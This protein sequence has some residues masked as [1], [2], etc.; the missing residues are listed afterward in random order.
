LLDDALPRD[1]QAALT[2]H[3]EACAAC[4]DLFAALA[5]GEP[6]W[7]AARELA[8]ASETQT[9]PGEGRFRAPSGLPFLEPSDEEGRIGR[10][11]PYEVMA[12]V[13]R[14]GMGV[15]LKA[16]D[17]SLH[18]VVAVKVLA[19]QLSAGVA[20]RKRFV[21]EARAAASVAHEHVVTIHA[22]DEWKGWPFLVMQYVGGKSLQERIDRSGPLEVKEILRIGMQAA[23][24]L[25]AAHAQGLVHRDIKP[26]NILLENGVERVKLTDFG[27]ARAVDDPSLTQAGVVAGTPQYMSPEQ[28]KGEAVD[29]RSDLFSL[30]S[31][32][33]A[34]ATGRPP[35]RGDSS[36]GV[37]RKVCDEEPRP[38]RESNTDIPTWLD[39][40]IRKLL[41]KDPTL[42]FTSAEEVAEVLGDYLAR[43]QRGEAIVE[44]VPDDLS[45]LHDAA[46]DVGPAKLAGVEDVGPEKVSRERQGGAW[47][48]AAAASVL[49]LVALGTTEA[50]GVT[51]VGELVATVLRIRV[52]EGILVLEVDDPETKVAIDGGDV[53]VHGG[54]VRELKL[55][56]GPHQVQALRGGVPTRVELVEI[57]KGDKQ[58]LRIG[59][60]PD[61]LPGI[62]SA[63][64]VPVSPDSFV[65]ADALRAA[66]REQRARLARPMVLERADPGRMRQHLQSAADESVARAR[67]EA[68]E[69]DRA[70]YLKALDAKLGD[71]YWATA[72]TI[73]REQAGSDEAL[74]GAILAAVE[75]EAAT[76][77]EKMGESRLSEAA[78]EARSRALERL[79]DQIANRRDGWERLLKVLEAG[80]ETLK[81]RLG[82]LDPAKDRDATFELTGRLK[83]LE[84]EATQ[85]EAQMAKAEE[86]L[87]HLKALDPR[88][89]S[90]AMI[91][92]EAGFPPIEAGP[93]VAG[94]PAAARLRAIRDE[95]LRREVACAE[96]CR[97]TARSLPGLDAA[98][99]EAERTLEQ[100]R[101]E[102]ELGRGARQ[103][104]LQAEIGRGTSRDT[105]VSA[106]EAVDA[107]ES[108]ASVWE[109][110]GEAADRELEALA[111]GSGEDGIARDAR[112]EALAALLDWER[113]AR[114]HARAA[115]ERKEEIFKAAGELM[116]TRNVEVE[117]GTLIARSPEIREARR[118]EAAAAGE[119]AQARVNLARRE[120]RLAQVEG[121]ARRERPTVETL[122][123]WAMTGLPAASVEGVIPVGSGDRLGGHPE[124][125]PEALI[126]GES[127][128]QRAGWIRRRLAEKFGPG[129]G[130]PDMPGGPEFER[131]MRRIG[132][133]LGGLGVEGFSNGPPGHVEP[134]EPPEPP[135][136]PGDVDPSREFVGERVAGLEEALKEIDAELEALK[137]EAGAEARL[138]VQV[139]ERTRDELRRAMEELKRERGMPPIP[140]T[141][142]PVEP[143]SP[144]PRSGE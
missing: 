89:T 83:K 13:G 44:E 93:M 31:V 70:E 63:V 85:I 142:P 61:G 42:R 121:M 47:R 9:H 110:I 64:L 18:R 114:D 106:H 22:V 78:T 49:G 76:L 141:P 40:L 96:G 129:R 113:A 73:A 52:P 5:A 23:Q 134:P 87:A 43:L 29:A 71:E 12:V 50:L 25:A 69:I 99:E 124:S 66:I 101:Q 16:F 10:F 7:E 27:L 81:E 36:I 137:G 115:L 127:P 84:A 103:E 108:A 41:A 21:R 97:E 60:E 37:I 8:Q 58:T 26:A 128:G 102:F 77:G 117:A 125:G 15:V 11:G 65:G 80:R 46:L 100:A 17:P 59:L 1:E 67:L 140:P 118:L 131:R 92:R 6:A 104:L 105:A 120:Q 14:G 75:A 32:L 20:A 45:G 48:W 24:G 138:Q 144:P 130:R 90:A 139:M 107:M 122:H 28:A 132:E 109:K 39:A 55:R 2:D 3:L 79:R 86:R 34:M 30:G 111:E 38:I 116:R 123:L 135:V 53:V 33:Y 54:G 126:Q 62:S 133:I 57:R 94:G 88:A 4:R 143:P 72:R 119:L 56:A 35:F 74:L 82:L 112:M 91:Y 98:A 51:R 136:M 95:C 68:G 19:P